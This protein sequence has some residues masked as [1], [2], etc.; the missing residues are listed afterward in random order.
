MQLDKPSLRRVVDA[1]RQAERNPRATPRAPRGPVINLPIK[2][3]R[4]TTTLKAATANGPGRGAAGLITVAYDSNDDAHYGPTGPPLPCYQ[5]DPNSTTAAGTLVIV[6]FVDGRLNVLTELCPAS[7]TT[8][9]GGGSSGG[10]TST[11]TG[12]TGS[13]S[14]GSTP[15]GF[16]PSGFD[17]AGFDAGGSSSGGSSSGGTP[18]SP[19]YSYGFQPGG[20]EAPGFKPGGF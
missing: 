14:N 12:S 8:T 17:P 7:S 5:F 20:F 1:T 11:G 3:A 2:Y 10:G 18:D 6:A 9:T 13:G 15:A 19:S 4:V 16:S